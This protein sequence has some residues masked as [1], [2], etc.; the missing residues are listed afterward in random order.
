MNRILQLSV[1]MSSNIGISDPV[2]LRPGREKERFQVI[3]PFPNNVYKGPLEST[4]VLPTAI[5]GTWYPKVTTGRDMRPNSSVILHIHGGAFVIGDGRTETLGFLANTLL[6]HAGADAVFAPQYRLSG[7]SKTNPFPAGLQDVLA[8]YLYL[9]QTLEIPARNITL[10]GDS[11]GGNLAI[12][13]LRYLSE[14]G[15]ELNIP[16]PQSAVLISPW[17]SPRNTNVSDIAFM[18]NPHYPTDFLPSEFTRWGAVTYS[19]ITPITDPYIT[20]LGNPFA[21]SVPIFINQGGAEVLEIDGTQWVEEMNRIEG[22]KIQSVYEEAAPHDT[23][24][25][26]DKI[27]WTE[28]AE[29]V[30]SQIGQ[31]IKASQSAGEQ[32]IADSHYEGIQG[33]L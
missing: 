30:A 7:Y 27:G 25:V 29:R 5:G 9:I 8:S 10:S 14:Y 2:T 23:L 16:N 17:V 15:K 6:K 33:K 32:P 28:S 21:T 26:G 11:A 19:A 20:A 1:D 4:T 22:N 13:F 24:L 12:A 31:F 18:T 3:R